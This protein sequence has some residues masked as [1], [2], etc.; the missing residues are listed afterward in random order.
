[1]GES[2]SS[3]WGCSDS[4]SCWRQLIGGDATGSSAGQKT[5]EIKI[6]CQRPDFRLFGPVDKIMNLRRLRGQMLINDFFP[7]FLLGFTKTH[8]QCLNLSL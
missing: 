7:G 8:Y 2:H 1:M 3:T 6:A 5:E 4:S